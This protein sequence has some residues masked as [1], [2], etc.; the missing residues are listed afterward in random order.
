MRRKRPIGKRICLRVFVL[1]THDF[2]IYGK[3]SL[4]V[5]EQMDEAEAKAVVCESNM[6]GCGIISRHRKMLAWSKKTLV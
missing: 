5:L 6:T 1:L 2:F 3:R 4:F